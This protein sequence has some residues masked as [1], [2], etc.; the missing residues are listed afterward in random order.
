[1]SLKRS[2]KSHTWAADIT[3]AHL[4]EGDGMNSKNALKHGSTYRLDL[5][6]GCMYRI[7]ASHTTNRIDRK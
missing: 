3:A 2:H 4:F 6:Q 5:H 7:E 1:M